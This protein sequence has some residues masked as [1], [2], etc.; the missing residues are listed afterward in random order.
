MTHEN[1]VP[2]RRILRKPSGH[3]IGQATARAPATCGELVQGMTGGADF[4]VTCPINQFA[5]ATV[6]LRADPGTGR[7]RRGNGDGNKESDAD[8]AAVR[9]VAH[10][11]KTRRAVALAL[12]EIARR[13]GIAA[14]LR[15]EVLLTGAI[16]AGKGMGSSSA[17]IAAAV[18][19]AGLAAGCAL[20]PA[21]IARIALSVEPTDGV[22]FP[23][24][25]LFDHRRGRIAES[26][27][28]P[29]P[30]EAIVIDRG[31]QVDTL[32]FNAVD[33]AAQ[34][35]AVAD[36]TEAALEPVHAGVRR[37]DAGLIGRGATVSARAGR[38]PDAAAWVERAIGL[39][40][41]IGA[42]G[43]NV[44]HSGTVIGILL[45]ARRRQSKPAYRRAV[46]EFGDAESVRHFRVI[47][48]GVRPA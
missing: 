7:Q 34:W 43:V 42:A 15:A 41:D 1:P 44:A 13:A 19:A 46:A 8:E 3:L 45:D 11:P 18:A 36:R 31:G 25:A 10:L 17:D 21:D 24:I 47:G 20:S 9:G 28:P 30:M 29:P 37:Q 6:T 39:A 4:L 14:P 48:G 2:N 38:P 5:Y 23:G 12:P 33:R 26:L 35:A 22:M 16:P 27:G 40:E 32:A